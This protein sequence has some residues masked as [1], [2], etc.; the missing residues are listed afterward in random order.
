MIEFKGIIFHKVKN[1][2]VKDYYYIS[3][4]GQILSTFWKTPRILKCRVDKDG[5]LD[6]GMVKL[7]GRRSPMRVHRLVGLTFLDNPND[8]PVI[9]HKNGVVG[10]NRVENLEWCTISHNTKHGYDKLGVICARQRIVRA[11]NITTNE[12]W[13]F[14]SV[15]DAGGFFDT[16][17]SGICHRVSGKYNNPS[18]YGK[19]KD[20]YFEYLGYANVTTI[21]TTT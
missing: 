15:N 2:N 11:T 7:N 4:C 6:M 19:L 21:E 16:T 3:K 13:I 14:E 1:A 9:N 8:Y 18:S 5:Y 10:D 20:I 12:T 17:P